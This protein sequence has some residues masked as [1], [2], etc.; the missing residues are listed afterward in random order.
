MLHHSRNVLDMNPAPPLFPRPNPPA[1]PQLERCQHLLQSAAFS[2]QHQPNSQIH[3]PDPRLRR[4]P[5]R[6][7]P[8]A[9]HRGQETLPAH[10]LFGQNFVAP[11]PVESNRRCA[12]K[13][14]WLGLRTR[15]CGSQVLRAPRPALDDGFL[16]RVRPPP[17]DRLARQ[18]DYRIESRNPRRW[19]IRQRIPQHLA[20]LPRRTPNQPHHF[21]PHLLE[22][23]HDRRS[24]RSRSPAHQYSQV[25]P[26][27]PRVAR[28]FLPA[29]V[30]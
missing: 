30:P 22:R 18:M 6:T 29:R 26:P 7:F 3:R 11:I 14:L 23:R 15:Q 19:K 1:K 25:K 21:R 27:N 17:D 10:A 24:D 5:A 4:D 20:S 8:L 28:A 2:A 12:N 16:L 9:A 13:H